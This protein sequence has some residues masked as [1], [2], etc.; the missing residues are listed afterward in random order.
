MLA[1]GLQLLHDYNAFRRLQAMLEIIFYLRY[2]HI[3]AF[4]NFR[5]R[6]RHPDFFKSRRKVGFATF[7]CISQHSSLC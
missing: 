3:Y 1:Q 5:N 2:I 7:S 6:Y 4:F